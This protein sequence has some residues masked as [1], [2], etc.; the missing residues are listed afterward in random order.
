MDTVLIAEDDR[1]HLT[2]LKNILGK[3][4]DKFEVIPAKDGQE[5]ID[6]LQKQP[7]SVLVTD[8]QMPRVDGLVLLAHVSVHHPNI[9][10]FVMSAYGTQQMKA[11][12][13]KGLLQFFPKPFEIEDLA[14]A[15]I[16][17]LERDEGLEGLQA[18]SVESFLHMI[19]MEQSS[20]VFEIKSPDKPTGLLS[21]EKGELYA[22][23]YGDLTGEAAALELIPTKNAS[24]GFK[25]YPDQ[26]VTRQIFT[27]LN[28]LV[29]KAVN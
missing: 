15:I 25:F 3:Y 6:A 4:A 16:D 29:R 28:D 11:K 24:F 22:A 14:R 9:P 26:P 7:V 1:I 17:V 8:I 18:I 20:C 21:F 23:E 2:R 12:L 13:P 19:H 27:D 5:A 10:C